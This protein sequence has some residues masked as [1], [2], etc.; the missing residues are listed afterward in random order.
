MVFKYLVIYAQLADWALGLEI[1]GL[2]VFDALAAESME[3][4]QLSW[5][6][7]DGMAVV[8]VLLDC[9]FVLFFASEVEV[10]YV[11]LQFQFDLFETLKLSLGFICQL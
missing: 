1:L 11:G 6:N 3:A 7:H 10:G 2:E 8:A 9:I 5:L 4:A